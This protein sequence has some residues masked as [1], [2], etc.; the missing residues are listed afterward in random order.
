MR[1]AMRE[2]P[3][4]GFL[5]NWKFT[6]MLWFG[7]ESGSC[8]NFQVEIS[9]LHS[10]VGQMGFSLCISSAKSCSM[11]HRVR[12]QEACGAASFGGPRM[13]SMRV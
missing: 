3:Q 5:L 12:S 13:N 4:R 10:V 8:C 11:D 2:K 9:L 6:D 7:F 1:S